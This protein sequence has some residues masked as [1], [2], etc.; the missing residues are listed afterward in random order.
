LKA[1]AIAL[2]D[3]IV[4]LM[5]KA[6]KIGGERVWVVEVFDYDYGMFKQTGSVCDARIM[7]LLYEKG[8]N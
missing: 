2:K 3:P 8:R 6:R 5:E 7:D 1:C 4:D